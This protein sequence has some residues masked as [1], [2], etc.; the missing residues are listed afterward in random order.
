MNSKLPVIVV[1]LGTFGTALCAAPVS[2]E[3]VY[4]KRCASCHESGNPRVP[5]RDALKKL[6]VGRI[7]RS[8]DFG[9]MSNVAS[10][11]RR[12]E[13]E[14]V[15]AYL[16]VAG[17]NPAPPA[18]A[19][20]PDRSVAIAGRSKSEW[21]G[22]SPSP[23]N[24][25]YQLGDAA[26]LTLDQVRKLKLKW[27]YGFDG[28]IVAFAQPTVLDGNVFVG[29]ASGQVQALSANSGCVKW[30]FQANA[31][32]RSAI[33]AVPLGEKHALLFGDQYGTFYSVEAETGRL[34]WKK[35]VDVQEAVKLTGAPVAYQGTVFIPASSWEEG[36]TLSPDYVCCTFRGWVAALRIKDGS[37]VW[38]AYTIREKP[39]QIGKTSAG[40]EQWGPS[41]GG[42]WA[43]PT[44][45]AKRG[46][47]YITTGDNF[48]PPSTDMSDSVVAL[49]LGTG[50]VAW[51]KQ[52]TPGDVWN[53]SCG[54]K[55]DCPGPD[56]D[57][58]SSVLLEKL[59]SGRDVL[60][61]GQKSGVVYALDP[62]KR[63]EIVW[64]VRVGK[65]GI[66]GGVQ[67]GMAS[68]G[69]RVYAATS[70][71][72]RLQGKNPDPLDP[73]PNLVDSAQGGGLTGLRIATGEK[74]WYTPPAACGTKPGCS[75]A[76]AAA[77]TAIPG[78]VFSGSMD[79]H[80]RAYT[81][82]EGR[83]LWDFD[84]V[85]EFETVN[86]VRASGGSLSG[87]GAVV[88]GGMVFVNSGYRSGS[89][90]GNVLL[91]FAPEE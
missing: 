74:A 27:A 26:G 91:A 25:R 68:D 57:Y 55:G 31:P 60:L 11:L 40:A 86:G 14:A 22:W 85:R 79:G 29:S 50:R 47:L 76:Q 63:G 62:D 16:G 81:A 9:E 71:V 52:T 21:N 56:Y 66:N 30:T 34:L 37:Q 67:W 90:P 24:T 12:D 20:C 45:D 58:G 33:V 73:S 18:K 84:T 51:S 10:S 72:A 59:E 87:P 83:I 8:L 23:T 48:S 70:D 41:G 53:S 77:V 15:A 36:R 75:P 69:Q 6:A 89:M 1:A 43:S 19:L 7:A 44:L 65:G 80:L 38:K 78:V 17:G 2:G 42:V 82:E 35:M 61:V 88:A 32:V 49:E 5:S 54:Q 3:A 28:D 4:Q 64:Q 13:R 46:L 39:R